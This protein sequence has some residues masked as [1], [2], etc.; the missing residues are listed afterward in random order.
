MS[1]IKSL[2]AAAML[3]GGLSAG[4]MAQEASYWPADT[5]H[6]GY[7]DRKEWR[8]EQAPLAGTATRIDATEPD[9]R[10]GHTPELSYRSADTDGDGYVSRMEWDRHQAHVMQ[11]LRE[12]GGAVRE[13]EFS[14]DAADENKDGMVTEAEWNRYHAQTMMR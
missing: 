9:A 6:D 5:N 11:A 4:A 3:V 7:V 2:A 8:Q 10:S 14:Y 12:R 1:N 13:G